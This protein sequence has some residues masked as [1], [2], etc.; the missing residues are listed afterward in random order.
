MILNLA[1]KYNGDIEWDLITFPD[2]D[3]HIDLTSHLDV[4]H[5]QN[6]LIIKTR[7]RTPTDLFILKQAVASVRSAHPL[8][9]IS[10]H[11]VYLLSARYDRQMHKHD[12]CNL[13]IVAKEINDLNCLRV[14]L[15]EPHS[16]ASTILIDR[17]EV[18]HPLDDTV[19]KR[20]IAIESQALQKVCFVTPDLGAVKR[21]EK[22]LS[23]IK[24]EVPLVYANKHRILST[25]EI[26]GIDIFNPDNLREAAFVYDDLCD[27]GRTFTELAKKLRATGIVKRIELFVTHGLFSKGTDILLDA[28]ADDRAYVSSIYT[29]N[30]YQE[31]ESN[32]AL[33]AVK[34]I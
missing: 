20:I 23:S 29:T 5:A 16:D 27:G 15:Y 34:I 9:Q 14:V 10:L 25:G 22:Y 12:A 21:T 24:R 18:I 2:G 17:C 19:T 28:N 8:V 26:T 7:L 4:I 32:H 33:T 6:M 11:I 30:S 1:N 31:I 3:V 13:K